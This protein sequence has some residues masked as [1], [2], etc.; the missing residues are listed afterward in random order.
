[1]RR[2][3]S[4][5]EDRAVGIVVPVHDEED[6]LPDA[7]H[8]LELA[9]DRLSP[10]I[11][12]RVV[13]ALDNCG[14]ASWT[15]GRCWAARSQRTRPSTT[16]HECW[17]GPAIRFLRPFGPVAG[18]G[19]HGD[20]VGDNRRRFTSAAELAHGSGRCLPIRHR[21]L[22]RKSPTFLRRAARFF[23][24][25]NATRLNEIRST[26]RALGSSA[27]TRNLEASEVCA[28]GEDRDLYER[29]VVAGFVFAT[30]PGRSL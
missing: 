3:S 30:T 2:P 6:L 12:C 1:M 19:P 8:A 26:G 17:A 18:G 11:S 4:R 14:D 28:S 24:G 10:S 25:R 15:I 29:A 27:A 16:V 21:P 23:G 7:L 13:L 20:V 5:G 22:G 9:I